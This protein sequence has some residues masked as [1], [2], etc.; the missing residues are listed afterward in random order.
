MGRITDMS[1]EYVFKTGDY[2]NRKI[3]FSAVVNEGENPDKVLMGLYHKIH[4]INAIMQKQIELVYAVA[5]AREDLR[6]QIKHTKALETEQSQ[7]TADLIKFADSLDTFEDELAQIERKRTVLCTRDRVEDLKEEIAA[8]L[9]VCNKYEQVL[10]D[11]TVK[12]SLIRKLALDGD[13][14]QYRPSMFKFEAPKRMTR[15]LED[16]FDFEDPD[17]FDDQDED[18]GDSDY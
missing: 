13:F 12:L 6:N 18:F 10:T 14:N 2:Q 1:Y 17:F 15:G 5:G 3:R 7:L 11:L 8:E 16:A 4:R 9:L